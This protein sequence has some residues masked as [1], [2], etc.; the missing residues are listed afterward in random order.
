M[1]ETRSAGMAPM[2][3]DLYKEF[4]SPLMQQMR[5]DAYGEDIGQHS[6]VTAAELREDLPG[7]ELSPSSHLLDLGCGPCGPLT[8]IL[9]LAGCRGTGLDASAAA[10]GV[11]RVRAESLGLESRVTLLA[12]DLNEPLP[13]AAAS[14]DAVMSLDVVLHLRD[15]MDLFREV[16]RVLEPRGR[17]LFSDAAVVTAAISD[18]EVRLRSTN[19]SCSFVPPGFNEEMLSFAGFQL[20]DR[21]DRSA[22]LLRNAAGRLAARL[23][24]RDELEGVEGRVVFDEQQRY[25]ETVI[26]LSERGALSRITYLAR[27]GT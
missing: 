14:C 2:Y 6:W 20:V 24:Y 4:D 15:R 10:I 8:F 26:A 16:A 11:G 17:F 22:S 5:R 1:S 25:L 12:A 21:Q 27:L 19:G 3:D 23:A 13:L 9:G 18:E 7:L